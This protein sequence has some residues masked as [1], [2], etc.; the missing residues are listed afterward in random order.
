MHGTRSGGEL[1]TRPAHIRDAAALAALLN[2]VIAEGGKTA[3]SEPLS[4]SQ[5]AEWFISGP[6]CVSCIVA[7]DDAG[8]PVGFQALERFHDDLAPDQADI[9][10]FVTAGMRGAGVGRELAHVTL[11]LARTK[12]LA[13]VRA[14]IRRH[15]QDAVRYYESLG[16]RG[17]GAFVTKDTVTLTYRCGGADM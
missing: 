6:H 14:T 12:R 8:R 15:N 5:C 2:A 1:R 16:F 13:S 10:T 3:I 17:E 7:V 9:A 11:G 4:A